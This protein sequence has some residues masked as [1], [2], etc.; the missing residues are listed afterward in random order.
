MIESANRLA[1]GVPASS[2]RRVAIRLDVTETQGRTSS[3]LRIG[4]VARHFDIS[5]DLLRLYERA[6]LLIPMKSPRGVRYFTKRDYPWIET[7]RRL[8]H[9]SRLNLADIRHIL[10]S[11]PCW[12]IRHCGFE[13]KNE[14]PLIS[15][16]WQPCWMN[17]AICPVVSPRVACYSCRVYRS[18]PNCAALKAVL[19][20]VLGGAPKPPTVSART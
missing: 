19:K 5:P 14:C 6:G 7:I 1:S 17:R 16:G 4:T 9:N 8:V 3:S 20:A 13:K 18:A 11:L 12:R 10:A 15:D 2:T